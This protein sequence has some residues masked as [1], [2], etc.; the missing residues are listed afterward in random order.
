MSPETLKVPTLSD[1][2]RRVFGRQAKILSLSLKDRAAILLGGREADY[3]G[4]GKGFR[5]S[6]YYQERGLSP[7]GKHVQAVLGRFSASEKSNGTAALW[8]PLWKGWNPSKIKALLGTGL[9]EDDDPSEMPPRPWKRTFPHR[10]S[11]KRRLLTS[12]PFGNEYLAK[13]ATILLEDSAVGL[14][15]DEIPDL[16]LLSFSSTDYI[17]HA[18]GPD[19]WE[20]ADA[21]LRLDRQLAK[22][23]VLLDRTVGKGNYVFCLSADHGVAPTPGPG[24]KMK[25][26][27]LKALDAENPQES[28]LYPRLAMALAKEFAPSLPEGFQ[29]VQPFGAGKFRR[30]RFP[31]FTSSGRVLYLRR[32][33]LE[34]YDLEV[35]QVSKFIRDWLQRQPEV[36][37]AAS[38]G[39]LRKLNGEQSNKHPIWLLFRNAYFP[40]RSGEVFY[41][42]KP[43]LLGF[44]P[45]SGLSASHGTVHPYDREVPIFFFGPGVPHGKTI[46]QP[47]SVARMVPTAAK[48]FGMVPPKT[49]KEDPLPL[50]H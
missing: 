33:I 35:E 3:V 30:I 18:F 20:V 14:G 28:G 12:S 27:D 46:H 1:Q 6:L 40:G 32:N 23:L 36:L 38:V 10:L 4:W 25:Y 48:L 9:R 50:K 13:A 37:E 29:A 26:L 17:G 5:T 15:R 47:V 22:L 31:L 39:D 43:H 7:L 11:S 19:S 34:K 44:L 41:A 16:F 8:E 24:S 45:R 2:W 42:L 21:F 49:C